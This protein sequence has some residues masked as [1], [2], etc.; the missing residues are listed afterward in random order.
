MVLQLH[1]Y[2]QNHTSIPRAY[3]HT[4][5]LAVSQD[6]AGNAMPYFHID[7]KTDDIMTPV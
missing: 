2:W 5:C 3:A 7:A 6:A 1:F 4:E